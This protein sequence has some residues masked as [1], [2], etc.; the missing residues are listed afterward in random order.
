MYYLGRGIRLRPKVVLGEKK[1]KKGL[2]YEKI[3]E[4]GTGFYCC[5]QF[6]VS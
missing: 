4:W 1:E 3:T 2:I 6:F 5:R